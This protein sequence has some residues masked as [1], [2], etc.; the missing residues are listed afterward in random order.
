MDWTSNGLNPEWTQPRMGL[1]P[2]W[3]EPRMG[4]NPEWTQPW[5]GLNSEWTEPRLDSTPTGTQPRLDRTQNGTESR[6]DSTS[7]FF[8]PRIWC[9]MV[10]IKRMYLKWENTSVYFNLDTFLSTPRIWCKQCVRWR[11]TYQKNSGL[12]LSRGWVPGPPGL[13]PDLRLNPPTET[14]HRNVGTQPRHFG[15]EYEEKP[16]QLN[17]MLSPFCV[18]SSHSH[19]KSILGWVPFRVRSF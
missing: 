18:E 14:E 10:Y 9:T 15:G 4:L 17:I 2:G 19:V 16:V 11:C 13:N 1:N 8:Q 5:M 12:S 3:T 6:L 7:N